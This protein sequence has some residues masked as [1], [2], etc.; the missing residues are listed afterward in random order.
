MNKTSLLAVMAILLAL[1]LLSGACSTST[2][3][4][5]RPI[6]EPVVDEPGSYIVRHRGPELEVVIGTKYAGS[7]IGNDWLI[8][9][10]GIGGM[11]SASVEVQR[12]RVS[13]KTPDGERFEIIQHQEFSSRYSEIAGPAR[14]AAIA[15]EPLDFTRS[16]RRECALDF[17]PL[18]GTG[19]VYEGRQVNLRNF[20]QGFLYFPIPGGVQ[21]G[22]YELRI[23]LEER[24]VKVPFRLE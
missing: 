23:E 11:E 8:L 3:A 24:Y 19:I 18:P 9:H 20:C 4:P 17:M 15:A 5:K 7:H 14:Q 12:N 22:P 2:P 10:V 13:L 16:G 6:T 1:A 21:P